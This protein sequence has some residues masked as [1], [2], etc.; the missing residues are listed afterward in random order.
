M[1]KPKKRFFANHA[2][3]S[4]MLVSLVLHL[5]LL[6][7]A[8]SFVAVS[9]VLKNENQ[10]EA[11]HVTRPKMPVKRLQVPVKMKKKRPKPKLRKQITVKSRMNQKMP[12]IKMPEIVGIKGG[13]GAAA[14]AAFDGVAGVGFSMPEVEVSV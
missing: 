8:A 13:M 6:V 4:A 10:F 9:V 5:I 1:D 14:G 11:P 7:M 12:D 2:K 3:S